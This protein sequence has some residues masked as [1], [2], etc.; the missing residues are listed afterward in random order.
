MQGQDAGKPA[1]E[2]FSQSLKR[3]EEESQELKAKIERNDALMTCPSTLSSA[4]PI[5][6]RKPQTGASIIQRTMSDATVLSVI[7]PGA[8]GAGSIVARG[9]D[10]NRAFRIGGAHFQ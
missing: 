6:K 8:H 2:D 9:G 3:L 7:L 1:G 10:P 5:G 4:T